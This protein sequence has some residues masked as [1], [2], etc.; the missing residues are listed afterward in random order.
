MKL[1]AVCKVPRTVPVWCETL[2][3]KRKEGPLPLYQLSWGADL[4]LAHPIHGTSFW[5]LTFLLYFL[6]VSRY[7][8]VAERT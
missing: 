8:T 2:G 7:P 4:R 6:R 1:A 5:S 3:V